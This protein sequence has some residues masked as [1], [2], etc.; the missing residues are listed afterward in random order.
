MTP[1]ADAESAK[2]V[3]C[4]ERLTGG[5]VTGFE[6]QARW[7]PSWNVA[8]DVAGE[9]RRV[10]VRGDR[11]AGLGTKPLDQEYRTL[12]VLERNG[13]PVPHIYGW[14]DDPIA[15]VMEH[16]PGT[17]YEGGADSDPAKRA[18]LEEYVATLGRIHR[19]DPAE[20]VAAGHALP[21]DPEEI[22]LT[23]FRMGDAA[24]RKG[25]A[26]PDALVEFVRGWLMRNIPRHRTRAVPITCDA[27]QFMHEGGRL[28]AFID[29]EMA[30]LGDPMADLASMRLRN[31]IEPSGDLARVYRH[32][33]RAGG[34]PLDR[35][36]LDFHT[37]V[38]FICVPM[39]SASTLRDKR[40]H[41]AFV[42]YFSWC[43]SGSQGAIA[44]IAATM[45]LALE[46]PPKI[47]PRPSA[48][49]NGLDDLVAHCAAMPA[50]QGFF[51]EEPLLSLARYARNVAAIG[52]AVEA[53][54]LDELVPI[55]GHRPA[56]APG[57]EAALEA[58]V[59]AAG[60]EADAMLL[61]YFYR[62][63][64]RRFQLIADYPSPIVGRGWTDISA[65][66]AG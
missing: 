1:P 44:T 6:P 54:E 55:L 22:A 13:I 3:A 9:T 60:P 25:K 26:G 15:I 42:E 61:R 48:Q 33:A 8:V 65:A 18:A 37:V 5:T 10:H 59:L 17:P 4:V 43:V 45:G 62:R 38:N 53:A 19:I 40:P 24:Y 39:I 31:T 46:P 12:C 2:L 49:L 63:E 35:A 11:A 47:A 50:P 16:V 34:E 58:F 28:R 23:Y 41:P 20:F 36:A 30:R 14:C 51:R 27:P 29:L 32:Y 21:A 66:F 64:T 57:A 56:D 7:R 52:D